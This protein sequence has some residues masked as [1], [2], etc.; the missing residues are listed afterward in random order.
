MV[1]SKGVSGAECRR[2]GN[3]RSTLYRFDCLCPVSA[4]LVVSDESGWVGGGGAE[5][6]E[7]KG[8]KI[9]RHHRIGAHSQAAVIDDGVE[10]DER[11]DRIRFQGR[12]V[13]LGLWIPLLWRG[14]VLQ[15]RELHPTGIP[16]A[17]HAPKSGDRSSKRESSPATADNPQVLASPHPPSLHPCTHPARSRAE[18]KRMSA[19]HMMHVPSKS[20]VQLGRSAP[21]AAAGRSGATT[22]AARRRTSSSARTAPSKQQIAPMSKSSKRWPSGGRQLASAASLAFGNGGKSQG[23]GDAEPPEEER[24]AMSPRISRKFGLELGLKLGLIALQRLNTP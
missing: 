5:K 18:M 20:S 22:A 21:P 23:T 19:L 8:S 2:G 1:V 11:L 4:C 24:R 15:R 7:G 14:R 6:E 12:D 3:G 16:A 10:A 17:K 13:Q 9:A